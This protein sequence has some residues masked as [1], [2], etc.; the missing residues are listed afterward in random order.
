MARRAIRAATMIFLKFFNKW[1]F[2]HRLS[3]RRLFLV[4]CHQIG[5]PI[6]TLFLR[7]IMFRSNL[8]APPL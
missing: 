6:L 7:V 1:E 3:D 4:I 8:P 5:I 2:F